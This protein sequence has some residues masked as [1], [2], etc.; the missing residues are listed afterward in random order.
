[1][2]GIETSSF[3]ILKVSTEL[4]KLQL[5]RRF[6][7]GSFV[8]LCGQTGGAKEV[9]SVKQEFIKRSGLKS[10]AEEMVASDTARGRDHL[11]AAVGS[12]RKYTKEINGGEI[13]AD[14]EI[15]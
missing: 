10:I 2:R 8:C 3:D 11:V 14:L 6:Q 9:G 15:R 5:G 13:A 1:M 4:G 7:I 12:Q